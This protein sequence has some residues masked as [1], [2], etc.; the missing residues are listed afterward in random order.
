[1]LEEK[2]PKELGEIAT[3]C[4][5]N[6]KSLATLTEEG[7]ICKM[8]GRHCPAQGNLSKNYTNFYFCTPKQN[9]ENCN[10]PQHG[11]TSR[12]YNN[13]QQRNTSYD[14]RQYDRRQRN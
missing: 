8:R 1:M 4:R 14:R 5:N 10:S 7:W 3:R 9:S 13:V 12:D 2:S 11:N 6:G